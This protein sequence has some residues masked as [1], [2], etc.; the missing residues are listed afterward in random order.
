[1]YILARNRTSLINLDNVTN[2]YLDSKDNCI[3]VIA[4][5]SD[6]IYKIKEFDSYNS[7]KKYYEKLIENVNHIN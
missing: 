7:A 5:S 6:K 1:M 4:G 3:K 2:L